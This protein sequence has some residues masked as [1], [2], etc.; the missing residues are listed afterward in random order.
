M[1][2]Q[3]TQPTDNRQIVQRFMDE[4]FSPVWGA[5]A[6]LIEAATTPP[7]AWTILFLDD[8][9]QANAL[10][11]HDL[12]DNGLPQSKVRTWASVSSCTNLPT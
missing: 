6:K 5:P 9:D 4:C 2:P 7:G 8:A 1:P 12:N 3:N 11:Y 10:G